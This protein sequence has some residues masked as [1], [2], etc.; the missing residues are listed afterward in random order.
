MASLLSY[1]RQANEKVQLDALQIK[2]NQENEKERKDT[3][4]YGA[5]VLSISCFPAKRKNA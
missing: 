4:E 3:V 1:S 5:L 2:F